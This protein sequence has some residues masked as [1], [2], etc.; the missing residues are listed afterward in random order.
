MTDENFIVKRK[1]LFFG[2]VY[3]EKAFDRVPR[4]LIRWAMHKVGVEE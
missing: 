1:K 3:L 2:F 4:E